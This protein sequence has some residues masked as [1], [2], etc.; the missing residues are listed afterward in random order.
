MSGLGADSSAV[1]HEPAPVDAGHRIE[2]P[3]SLTARLSSEQVN[4][5]EEYARSHTDAR[6]LRHELV[7][8]E[9]VRGLT[10]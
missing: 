2:I 10:R 4:K 6:G 7:E 1:S 8:M 5:L 3:A 9:K